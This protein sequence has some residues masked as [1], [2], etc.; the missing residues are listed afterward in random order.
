MESMRAN[1]NK[2]GSP[3]GSPDFLLVEV[4]GFSTEASENAAESRK[5]KTLLRLPRFVF[6]QSGDPGAVGLKCIVEHTEPHCV[7]KLKLVGGI[8]IPLEYLDPFASPRSPSRL[9]PSW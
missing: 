6:Y 3:R 9:P 4:C 7:P 5:S 2:A 1:K 8:G